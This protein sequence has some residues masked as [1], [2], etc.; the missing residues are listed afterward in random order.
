MKNQSGSTEAD[1]DGMDA[2]LYRTNV[3]TAP[4]HSVLPFYKLN[5]IMRY[6]TRTGVNGSCMNGSCKSRMATKTESPTLTLVT[7]IE[8]FSHNA[9]EMNQLHLGCHTSR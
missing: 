6:G 7:S 3:N 5:I 2:M 9:P 1:Q 4:R 8:S